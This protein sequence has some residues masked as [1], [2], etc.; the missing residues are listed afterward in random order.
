[1]TYNADEASTYNGKPIELYEFV[2]TY[3]TYRYTSHNEDVVLGGETYTA[4]A[5]QRDRIKLAAVG[6][7]NAD[8]QIRM[9]TKEALPTDYAFVIAPPD[10]TLTLT[11][12]HTPDDVV[13]YW[14]GTVTAISVDGSTC[15]LTSPSNAGRALVIEAPNIMC[16][17][18]CNHVLGNAR[19][20]VDLD[21]LSVVSVI[22]GWTANTITVASDGGKPDD[23][24]AAGE[25]VTAT[26]R[27]TIISH[28]GNVLTLNYPLKKHRIG[29]SVTLRP[30]CDHAYSGDCLTKFN[31]QVNFGGCPFIPTDNPF[32]NGIA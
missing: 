26:E 16:Q 32:S 19:C 3:K 4:V 21:A 22:S 20:K 15:T 5:I 7:S 31:N 29:T 10:L 13:T 8:L 9:A 28:V 12:Y 25:L 11:R 18:L 30:G 2:G 14:Q 27:R 24:F 1:M 23:Y 6:G 17:T